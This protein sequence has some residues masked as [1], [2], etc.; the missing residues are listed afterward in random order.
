MAYLQL[1]EQLS[2]CERTRTFSVS[3]KHPSA[4]VSDRNKKFPLVFWVA[5]VDFLDIGPQLVFG[6]IY[7]RP[8]NFWL[9]VDCTSP[10]Y[11]F[12]LVLK[13]HANLNLLHS[14]CYFSWGSNMSFGPAVEAK[15]RHK[16]NFVV[17]CKACVRPHRTIGTSWCLAVREISLVVN[18]ENEFYVGKGLGVWDGD[19]GAI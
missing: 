4:V 2:L 19:Y 3:E 7:K 6:L 13:V 5:P 12:N 16:P 9:R 18:V 15:V 8:T 14:H 10:K 1:A 17:L 11:L